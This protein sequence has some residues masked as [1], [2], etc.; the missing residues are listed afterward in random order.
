MSETVIELPWPLLV[1]FSAAFGACV[2]SFLNVVIHRVPRGESIVTPRSR[3]PRCGAAIPAWA[4]LPLISYALL[5]GR[6]RGCREPISAR[7]PL[8]E[9]LTAA[10][11]HDELVVIGGAA[12]YAEAL[13]RA[14]RV[15]LTRV[16]AEVTGDVCFPDLDPTS[17]KE[18]ERMDHAADARH[19]HAFSI[20][21]LERVSGSG[22]GD[23]DRDA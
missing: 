21:T 1:G 8:V 18:V 12:V 16:H 11:G 2:G 4:N 9:A 5:R 23:G 10:R 17:W 3:C 14:E 15:Y 7:Y 13:P 19:A 22:R 20:C 6:C